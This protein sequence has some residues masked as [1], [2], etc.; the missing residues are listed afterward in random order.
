MSG[1]G[2][3]CRLRN[4]TDHPGIYCYGV[5]FLAIKANAV[6][7]GGGIR[8]IGHAGAAGV[9]EEEGYRFESVA[10]S[11][12]GAIIASL[13]A[14]GYTCA[15]LK[16]IMENTDY[17]KFRQE[18]FLDHLGVFG[19][20]I[21]I[22]FDYGIYSADYF[23]NWLHALLQR[24][25]K[26]TFGDIWRSPQLGD[27]GCRLHV[28]AS[29]LTD[30]KLLVFPEDLRAFCDDPN[31]FSIAKAV[32]MS[33][34][35]P[36]FYEPVKLKDKHGKVHYIV[37]GGLLSNYPMWI[38]DDGKSNPER[39]VFGFKFVD[40]PGGKEHKDAGKMNV[41]SYLTSIVSTAVDSLDQR[42]ISTSRGDYQRTVAIPATIETEGGKKLLSATDFDVTREESA[43]LYQNGREAAQRFLAGWDFQRWKAVYRNPAAAMARVRGQRRE[44]LD[45][46][47]RGI[48]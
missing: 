4:N 13:I 17:L 2:A 40:D 20:L 34:S 7:E 31:S 48:S 26:T 11:S 33:M 35:I 16:T 10:G 14:V 1:G 19:K 18:S 15:E 29:D 32:R 44:P 27:D 8:G 3:T 46:T 30:K 45:F 47:Q 9:F 39:P 28:T 24:K 21:E 38:L 37:D 42:Y 22:L 25:G 6:F 23:E 5:I 12:A 43:A 36:L 41:F